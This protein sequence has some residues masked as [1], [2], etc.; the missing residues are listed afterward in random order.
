M[1]K[2]RRQRLRR[3]CRGATLL[4]QGR[5]EQ[6]HDP[7]HRDA[8]HENPREFANLLPIQINPAQHRSSPARGSHPGTNI[9]CSE[10]NTVPEWAQFRIL[11]MGYPAFTRTEP[12]RSMMSANRGQQNCCARVTVPAFLTAIA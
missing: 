6:K 5:Q 9:P 1:E 10:R 12:S 7:E 4:L 11:R 2:P 3:T 8:G